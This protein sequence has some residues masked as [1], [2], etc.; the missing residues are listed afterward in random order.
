MPKVGLTGNIG[1]GKS[2]VLKILAEKKARIYDCDQKVHRIYNNPNHLVCRRVGQVF[3]KAVE[4]GRISR[5]KLSSIVFNNKNKLRKLEEIVHPV[6]I[7]ELKKWLEA[8]HKNKVAVAEVPLLF[9]KG[10]AA[11][12]DKTVF[13]KVDRDILLKRLLKKYKLSKS[14]AEKRLSLYLPA[15]EKG[16]RSDFILENNSNLSDLKKEVNLLWRKISKI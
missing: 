5:E 6:I 16:K 2:T 13:V 3:P 9:E 15:E 7:S 11:C 8:G 1:S 14:E 12:F 4:K 10:L